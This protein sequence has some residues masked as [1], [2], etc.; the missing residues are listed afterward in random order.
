MSVWN[1]VF[2]IAGV[3]AGATAHAT[4]PV[5]AAAYQRAQETMQLQGQTYGPAQQIAKVAFAQCNLVRSQYGLAEVWPE[6]ALL[7]GVDQRV[8]E[9][10]YQDGMA[11]TRSEGYTLAAS[12][13][14]RW[15]QDSRA[16]PGTLPATAP[17]CSQARKQPII[18]DQLWRDGQVY[19]IDHLK[20]RIR[21][22]PYVL[23]ERPG[24]SAAQW[25]ELPTDKVLGHSCIRI[26]EALLPTLLKADFGLAVPAGS[27][28]KLASCL[29]QAVPLTAQYNFPWPLESRSE[30]SMAGSVLIQE[31]HSEQLTLGQALPASRFELPAGYSR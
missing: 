3:I 31:V 20:K 16:T 23:T 5:P 7:Q 25:A 11:R 26:T 30:M 15:Q 2:V 13:F 22:K 27:G 4:S 24:L 28:S 1:K 12:D 9:R 8:I 29:W 19:S 10:F 6:S 21:S 18:S 17:D 14:E